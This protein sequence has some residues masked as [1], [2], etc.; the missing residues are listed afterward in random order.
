MSWRPNITALILFIF[1]IS[2][3]PVSLVEAQQPQDQQR[4][5]N[6][7]TGNRFPSYLYVDEVGARISALRFYESHLD[8]EEYRIGTGDLLALALD[9][10]ISGTM[11]GIRVNAQGSIIV[12]QVGVI[13]IGGLLFKE[14]EKKINNV[15]SKKLPETTAKLQLEQPRS[16]QVHVTGNIP[17]AGPQLVYA[18]TRLDQAIYRSFFQPVPLDDA[19]KTDD[20]HIPTPQ[21]NVTDPL[22]PIVMM[23][24]K[25]PEA[26]FEQGNYDFRNIAINRADGTQIKADLVRYFKAGDLDANPIVEEKDIIVINRS[27]EYHPKVSI[28]GAVNTHLNLEYREDDT[29]SLLIDMAGGLSFDAEPQR[30]RIMRRTDSGLEEVI[31][32]RPEEIESYDVQP[33][34]RIIIPYDRSKRLSHSASV[35]G[36]TVY[37][38]RFPIE[39]GVTTLYDLIQ[40]TGGLTDQALPE[41]AYMIR[42]APAKTEFG[43]FKNKS[44]AKKENR[45][46]SRTSAFGFRPSFHPEI[47]KRTS[48]QFLEGFEYLE[49]ESLL[50]GGHVPVDLNNEAQL[51]EITLFDGDRLQI[52]R[53]DGTV[54]V[55]GQVNKPGYYPFHRAWSADDFIDRADGF[56]LSADT[57]RVFVI[58]AQTNSWYKAD[59]V[60]IAPGDLVFV[61]R[62]PFED[63][64]SA[65]EYELRKQI[66]RNSRIQIFV[67]GIATI[68]SV[69]TAFAAITR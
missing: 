21:Y 4:P 64:H 58:K 52:P 44:E 48:D 60:S 59:E 37:T 1:L 63:L 69:V 18:Q 45:V 57:D 36:E 19:R 23:T 29:I 47:L 43:L 13:S 22:S 15:F 7:D 67:T 12:P 38:G 56:A 68:A 24:N 31:L 25:F 30:V 51:K 65:R 41:G 61:D 27:Y 2:G 66:N 53:N 17:Y 16:I 6:I 34:D 11:R 28:S 35:Y 5:L 3:L 8:I 32:D 46:Q 55:F 20:E 10:N 50:I 49:L 62:H 42:T 14:A 33:N 39:E 9:G 54:F 26:F 40:L